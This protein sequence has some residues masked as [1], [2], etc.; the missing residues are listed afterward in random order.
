M[1]LLDKRPDWL[2]VLV[3]RWPARRSVALLRISLGLVF[4]GF[5][6]SNSP[7]P[8]AI[9]AGASVSGTPAVHRR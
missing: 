7:S 1:K 5:G 3:A 2:Q 4:L 9:V 6:A 8:E